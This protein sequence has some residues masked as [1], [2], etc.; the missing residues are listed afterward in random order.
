MR[1]RVRESQIAFCFIDLKG[2]SANVF[3][4]SKIYIA[5][6]SFTS[7]LLGYEPP[8]LYNTSLL[9]NNGT[10]FSNT[11]SPKMADG[12]YWVDFDGEVGLTGVFEM[13]YEFMTP[14]VPW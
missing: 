3:T 2:R 7:L 1:N 6:D 14:R 10:M 13:A 8:Q 5:R 4:K 12:R 11:L 9:S